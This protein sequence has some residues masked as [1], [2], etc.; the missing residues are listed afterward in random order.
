MVILT[1]NK[2]AG[3]VKLLVSIGV[4]YCTMFFADAEGQA[5]CQRVREERRAEHRTKES[6]HVL[7]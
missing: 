4:T 6:S 5:G 1:G 2:T 3:I 7:S